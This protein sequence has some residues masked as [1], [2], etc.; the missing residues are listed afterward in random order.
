MT[1]SSQY[2]MDLMD[3]DLMDQVRLHLPVCI[4][5]RYGVIPPDAA[6]AKIIPH[7]RVQITT[8]VYMRGPIESITSPS[9]T[10]F[11]VIDGAAPETPTDPCGR[12]VQYH[13]PDFLSRDF[14][15]SIKAEG[16]DAARCFAER[17]SDGSVALQLTV[18]PQGKLPLIASQEYIFL[19]DRSG[20]MG[21]TRID[22]AKRA[23]IML[24]RALPRNGTTF[25]IFSFG[26]KCDG[27]WGES[28][29]YNEKTLDEAVRHSAHFLLIFF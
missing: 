1:S 19:V 24:L 11:T 12:V 14:V 7:E 9:H 13:S 18:T 22:T 8:E 21:G 15:L 2:V 20:S 10:T 6:L 5:M 4:G 23:L 27:L 28:R 25:N 16:L 26:T 17:S 3:D 29:R